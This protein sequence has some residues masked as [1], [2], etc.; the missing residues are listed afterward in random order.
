M[1]VSPGGE[2]RADYGFQLENGTGI[3]VG[4]FNWAAVD[5]QGYVGGSPQRMHV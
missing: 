1:A 3:L 5:R 2:A 4:V